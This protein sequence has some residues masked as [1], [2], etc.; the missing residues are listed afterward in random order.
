MKTL[1][2]LLLITI[3]AICFSQ[4]INKSQVKATD[5]LLKVKV[6]D[7]KHG[8]DNFLKVSVR[9][10]TGNG[11]F[12][13]CRCKDTPPLIGD[14]LTIVNPVLVDKGYNRKRNFLFH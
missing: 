14:T 9:D 5:S 12:W 10:S 2:I 8:E 6:I 1:L 13:E 11:Y 3:P 7:V 4:K